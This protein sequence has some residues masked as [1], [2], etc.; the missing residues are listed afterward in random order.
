MGISIST[1]V[2]ANI[3]GF[4]GRD[5][6]VYKDAKAVSDITDQIFY[7]TPLFFLVSDDTGNPTVTTD[8]TTVEVLFQCRTQELLD[9][10]L[11]EIRERSKSVEL[12]ANQISFVPL[13]GIK[14][15]PEFEEAS[16]Y[17][18][19]NTGLSFIPLSE[20]HEAKFKFSNVET[21][22]KFADRVKNKDEDFYIELTIPSV[23]VTE[24]KIEISAGDFRKVDWKNLVND[25]NADKNIDNENQ[26]FT[27]DQ[28]SNSFD[29]ILRSIKITIVSDS[30][31]V[32]AK[33]LTLNEKKELLDRFIQ[34]L[35]KI[36]AVDFPPSD[37]KDIFIDKE[38]F[39][40][41]VIT[42]EKLSTSE[43]MTSAIE[44]V[45]DTAKED[46]QD[47]TKWSNRESLLKQLD[48]EYTNNKGSGSLATKVNVFDI[49]GGST[50]GTASFDFT[51][52]LVRQMEKESK[53]TNFDQFS[54]ST[55]DR[56]KSE[57]KDLLQKESNYEWEFEGEKIVPKK[58]KLRRI[59]S[60]EFKADH[61]LLQI[62]RSIERS[63]TEIGFP[64]SSKLNLISL[65]QLSDKGTRACIAMANR[66]AEGLRAPT[67]NRDV[68][69][70]YDSVSNRIFVKFA[71]TSKGEKD[72]EI[73]ESGAAKTAMTESLKHFGE[74]FVCNAEVFYIGGNNSVPTQMLP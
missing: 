53:Q 13:I 37:A 15:I 56:M 50:N 14:I 28:I 61:Q 16:P 8:D 21:A 55:K 22:K 71:D 17:T 24:D 72:R 65:Q 70:T 63:V 1:E 69:A 38:S 57:L 2:F 19:P 34:D 62:Y 20:Q 51:S 49:F 46:I 11:N 58:I 68:T 31:K 33:Q 18:Y 60:G 25:E 41:D 27:I 39:K 4:K 5:I 54:T 12:S 43:A 23:G 48:E 36:T 32:G 26:A 52:D 9:L 73:E 30:A 64:T 74:S 3:T 66:I 6:L 35:T 10:I 29:S 59:I 40:P 67:N 47:G 44:K 42:K 7:H 45:I